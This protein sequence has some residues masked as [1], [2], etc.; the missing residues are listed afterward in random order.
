M[1]YRMQKHMAKCAHGSSA[2]PMCHGGKM[3]EGGMAHAKDDYD[4]AMVPPM[5]HNAAA[6]H[7]DE[8]MVERIMRQRY[9][10]G[11]RVANETEMTADFEPNQFDDLV[12]DDNLEFSY[13]GANSG[14][15]I[16]N[17]Q[18][19]EDDQDIVKRAMR[20]W[21]KKDRMPRPA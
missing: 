3:A 16:G 10:M 15:E 19:D 7:E 18:V 5:K 17:E 1:K 20:S 6:M 4:P 8:D 11:G 21:A 14:D 9:S 2:C 12:K 13:T